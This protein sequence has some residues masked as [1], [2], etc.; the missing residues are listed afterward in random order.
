MNEVSTGQSQGGE[1]KQT[2]HGGQT[3]REGRSDAL[4]KST[5]KYPTQGDSL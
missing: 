4:L 3:E 2:G 1:L 5:H